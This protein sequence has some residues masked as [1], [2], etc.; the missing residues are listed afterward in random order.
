MHDNTLLFQD[1]DELIT[2]LRRSNVRLLLRGND[3]EVS[4]DNEAIEEKLLNQIRSNKERI[5][6]YLK[7]SGAQSPAQ[8]PVAPQQASY[9]L[10]SSQRRMWILNQMGQGAIAYNMPAVYLLEG[11]LDRQALSQSLNKLI[12]RHE[13]L[14]TVFRETSNGEVHQFII[15][16]GALPVPLLY[17]DLT[18]EGNA[19]AI[20]KDR[21]QKE[22]TAHFDLANGPL[23]RINLYRI[24]T[25]R[26]VLSYVMHHIISDGWSMTV[27]VKELMAYYNAFKKEHSASPVVPL[28]IQYRDFAVWQQQQLQAPTME[29]HKKYWLQ[30]FQDELPTLDLPGYQ[31]RPAIKTYNGGSVSLLL[32]PVAGNGMRS[33]CRQKG[34]T[35]FMG[36]LAVVNA[37]LYRYTSQEDIIVGTPITGREHP[38]LENQIGLYVN[39]LPLRCRFQGA[40]HFE[41]LLEHVKKVTLGAYACQAYPFD[42]ILEHIPIQ[43]DISRNPFFDVMVSLQEDTVSLAE[44]EGHIDELIIKRSGNDIQICKF[45]LT[46]SFTETGNG[47]ELQLGYN[48]D[49]YAHHFIQQMAL[50]CNQLLQSIVDHPLWPL[51]SHSCITTEEE[52]KLLREFNKQPF[53][54]PQEESTLISQWEQQV[55]K[56][57]GQLALVFENTALTYRQ[58]DEKANQLGNYLQHIYNIAPDELTGIQLERSE[59]LV[60]SILAVL[61]SGGAYVPIDPAYPEQ[62]IQHMVKDAGCKAII[63]E[64]ELA[65][66]Q[67][68]A[69]SYS[70]GKPPA[71][72]KSNQLAYM[73][74]TSGSTGMPK[75]VMITHGSIS[76]FARKCRKF[77]KSGQPV[78]MPV[79]ASASFDIS[80]FELFLPLLNGGTAMLVA[81]QEVKDIAILAKKLQHVTAIHAVPALMAQI[82]DKIKSTGT[83]KLYE[84]VHT[85]FIGGDR[86]PTPVLQEMKKVFPQAHIHVLYGPTESTIFVSSN[87]YLP[88]DDASLKGSVIGKPDAHARIY[89]LDQY[90]RVL[91]AGV[92]G[93]ICV[94]GNILAKGYK[95]Q[96]ALTDEKF[97]SWPLD[98]DGRIYRTGDKGKWLPDGTVEYCG[99]SDS[100]VKV[101]GYRIETAEIE[102]ALHGFPGIDAAVVLDIVNGYGEVELALY[103]VCS[104]ALNITEVR[105]HLS[106]VLPSYMLPARII[107]LE[108]LPV[109]SNGKLDTRHLRT[110]KE[111]ETASDTVYVAPANE[112]ERSIVQIWEEVLERKK[113]GV[114]DNFFEAGG[115]S[116]KI[117]RVSRKLSQLLNK[118]IP[119]TI[120]FQYP[121]IRDLVNFLEHATS[122]TVEDIVFDREQLLM[123]LDKFN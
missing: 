32:D 5:V 73:I 105:K 35:L 90:Q 97:I 75:G 93:E 60:I 77:Y 54:V 92:T 74:Y 44:Q 49:I 101:R 7:N 11:S 108:R 36:M 83:E 3:L 19:D 50:N 88:G 70:T 110:I 6:A 122:Y 15:P 113:I 118:D 117:V 38:D 10:S 99:R 81:S 61:K 1:I 78:V 58:L 96:P 21:I 27:L 23:L 64:K 100:Q 119:V 46:F 17:Y 89:I 66:F 80:L 109:T 20:V 91:P 112:T 2:G 95:N 42:E 29:Q 106:R 8:I 4:M 72:I 76:L 33:L 51:A 87:H 13:S 53:A 123:D 34:A 40:A 18:A 120:L 14:R 68:R 115:N 41:Q 12:E 116:I 39:S 86:V 67:T 9:V 57:P 52:N 79:M 48:S 71:D 56:T 30:Q 25:N 37:L 26:W 121:N 84:Q 98:P 107:R 55:S 103:V 69:N 111:F 65:V 16:A 94:G 102:N 43:R 104:L 62:R 63:D 114:K 22:N 45:D 28:R 24:A 31:L 82:T 85:L 59:W 47:L